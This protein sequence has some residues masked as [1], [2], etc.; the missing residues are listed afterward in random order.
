WYPA[1]LPEYFIRMLT[2]VGDVVV[3]PFAGSCITGEVAER[4]SRQWICGELVKEYLQGAKGRFERPAGT[5]QTKTSRSS[6][7]VS[8]S[9]Y[10]WNGVDGDLLPGD[11]GKERPKSKRLSLKKSKQ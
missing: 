9:A 10:L 2:D 7:T 1:E 6:Y 4:L 5:E 11:G 3:D 8:N